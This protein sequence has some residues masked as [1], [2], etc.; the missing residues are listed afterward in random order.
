MNSNHLYFEESNTQFLLTT[1]R[2]VTF[3][4]LTRNTANG[5][6]CIA[7]RMQNTNQNTSIWPKYASFSRFYKD[8]SR[9]IPLNSTS[10]PAHLWSHGYFYHRSH[11]CSF[12]LTVRTV[13]A[14]FCARFTSV[15]SLVR[16]QYRP[17]QSRA[18]MLGFFVAF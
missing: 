3:L 5:Q 4:F 12:G 11:G 8:C 1:V 13:V 6:N 9:I 14:N 10:K 7:L 17:P 16:V 18:E 15:R 2:T